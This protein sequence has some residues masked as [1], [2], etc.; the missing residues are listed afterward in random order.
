MIMVS[1]NRKPMFPNISFLFFLYTIFKVTLPVWE[2][3]CLIC[4]GVG[5][6]LEGGVKIYVA[7]KL[8]IKYSATKN[9]TTK[10]ITAIPTIC[11]PVIFSSLINNY[12]NYLL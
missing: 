10:L 3:R 2:I 12:T 5:H 7:I 8:A 1:P 4:S 11:T 9:I 6:N